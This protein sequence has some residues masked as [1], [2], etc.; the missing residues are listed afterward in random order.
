MDFNDLQKHVNK[1]MINQNNRSILAFEGYSP[2]EMHHILHF[3]FGDESPLKLKKL[4]DSEY[5]KVPIL[6]QIKYVLEL[7]KKNGEIKLTQKGY[8]STKIVSEI[9]Q[10]GFLKDEL[11]EIGI[12]KLYKETDSITVNLTRI[13]LGLCGLTIKR[14]D[15][16]YMT[17]L[18]NEIIGDNEALLRLI[19]LTYAT[20][21]NWAYFDGYGENKIGDLG[22]GFSL[23]LLSKYGHKKQLDSFYAKKYFEAFPLLLESI[24]PNYG[25]LDVYASNCYSI[26][27]FERFL[28]YFGLIKIDVEKNGYESINYITKTDLFDR[29]IN[30]LP[31][32]T[33]N[34]L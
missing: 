19:L 4:S 11:I 29:L 16:L 14:K 17:K 18:S 31:H 24:N 34:T 33:N 26:R 28:Y 1:L 21:F 27:T 9:Y 23:I 15:K 20:K 6:N 13:L 12:I 32:R 5:K 8:F 3:T 10:Q 22:Y 2:F 30:C 7:I 25:T